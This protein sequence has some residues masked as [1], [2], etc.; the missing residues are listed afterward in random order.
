MQKPGV[1]ACLFPILLSCIPALCQQNARIGE[2]FATTPQRTGEVLA[3]S[4]GMQVTSGSELA[5]GKSAAVLKLARG[6]QVRICPGTTVNVSAASDQGLAFA[7]GTGAIEINY[8]IDAIADSVT[9]PDFKLMLAGPGAFHFALGVNGHGDTCFRP[10][11]GNNSSVIV[12][13]TAGSGAYQLKEGEAVLFQGGNLK[14]RI[15]LQED[16]GCPETLPALTAEAASKS[17][18]E[19]QGASPAVADPAAPEKAEGTHV[20]VDTPFVYRA[21]NA[22]VPP[23]QPVARIEVASLPNRLLPQEPAVAVVPRKA[24]APSRP[25]GRKGFFGRIGSFFASI[26]RH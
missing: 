10:R 1:V 14:A 19:A 17:A 2:L 8:P 11:M 24:E 3:A 5:A 22:P 7:L 16:C 18:P 9:T 25:P 23:P 20:Q 4:S 6:G 15:P 26:F 21:E 12:S 13:E